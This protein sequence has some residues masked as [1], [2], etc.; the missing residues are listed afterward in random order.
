MEKIIKCVVL[1]IV[2]YLT[3]TLFI[4]LITKPYYKDFKGYEIVTKEPKIQITECK[5][6]YTKGYIK[7]TISNTT[8]EIIDAVCIKVN[9]YNE[10]GNY[11]GTEYYPI[12]YFYPQEEA[13]FEVKY[14]YKDIGHIKIEVE[15]K[16][17]IEDKFAIFDQIDGNT[18]PYLELTLLLMNPIIIFTA[19]GL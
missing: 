10:K 12:L 2:T 4:N 15:N 19:L 11:L 16:K 9:L 8:D 18:I 13:N 17:L 1:L 6:S 5:N 3:V 14:S 7:G